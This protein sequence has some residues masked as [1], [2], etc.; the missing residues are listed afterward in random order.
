MAQ[1]PGMEQKLLLTPVAQSTVNLRYTVHIN[2]ISISN[3]SARNSQMP[4]SIGRER[5]QPIFAVDRN[6]LLDRN[7]IRAWPNG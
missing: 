2:S 5:N 7:K 6:N 4:F 3:F 1:G